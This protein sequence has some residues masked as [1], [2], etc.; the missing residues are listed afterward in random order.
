IEE[1]V[2]I[3]QDLYSFNLESETADGRIEGKFESTQLRPRF[4]E[5]LKHF[6]LSAEEKRFVFPPAEVA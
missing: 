2:I 5:K 6:R 4:F 3:T 1:D